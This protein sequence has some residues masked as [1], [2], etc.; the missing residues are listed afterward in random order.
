MADDDTIENGYVK[1]SVLKTEYMACESPNSSTIQIGIEPAFNSKNF[2]Y[3]GLVLHESGNIDHEDQ[4]PI[5]S[6]SQMAGSCR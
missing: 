3:Q 5:S 2:R 6:L 4:A 1:L